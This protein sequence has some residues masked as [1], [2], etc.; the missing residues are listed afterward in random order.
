MVDTNMK[1]LRWA[2]IGL[3]L[4]MIFA[5]FLKEKRGEGNQML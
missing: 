2:C 1:F 3:A 5:F 4:M